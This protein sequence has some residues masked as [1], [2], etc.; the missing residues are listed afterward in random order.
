MIEG[1]VMILHHVF[2]TF[3]RP[4]GEEHTLGEY[5]ILSEQEI[6]DRVIAPLDEQ[7][8]ITLKE[9]IVHPVN[10]LQ[11]RIYRSEKRIEV[12]LLPDG[13][14]PVETEPE[15]VLYYFDQEVVAGVEECT[16]HFLPSQYMLEDTIRNRVEIETGSEDTTVQTSALVLKPEREQEIHIR[17]FSRR[18][19]VIF[20]CL[21]TF[22]YLGNFLLTSM[23]R[24]ADFPYPG[25]TSIFQ[26][27]SIITSWSI[28]SSIL[29]FLFLY[30]SRYLLIKRGYNNR[31]IA[32]TS[33]CGLCILLLVNIGMN[34]Q[35]LY[36]V[37][38]VQLKVMAYTSPYLIMIGVIV[39]SNYILFHRFDQLLLKEKELLYDEITRVLGPLLISLSITL[40]SGIFVTHL[41]LSTQ[42]RI[43]YPVWLGYLC[44]G[45][46]LCMLSIYLQVREL[47]W[48]CSTE[49]MI[50][51]VQD[52]PPLDSGFGD[53]VENSYSFS[54]SMPLSMD[55][56]SPV[57]EAIPEQGAHATM[58]PSS[59]QAPSTRSLRANRNKNQ[60][61]LFFMVSSLACLGNLLFT[62]SLRWVD[63]RDQNYFSLV[64]REQSI[65]T[66]WSVLSSILVFLLVSGI[67]FMSVKKKLKSMYVA[68]VTSCA[69]VLML[70]INVLLT[71]S[72]RYSAA[73]TVLVYLSPYLLM[74]GE[75]ALILYTWYY[76]FDHLLRREKALLYHLMMKLWSSILVTPFWFVISGVL[77]TFGSQPLHQEWRM[78][79]PLWFGYLLL[80]M[81][82]WIFSVRRNIR[83]LQFDLATDL[84]ERNRLPHLPS[85]IP[86]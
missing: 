8:F 40:L 12:L 33:A 46:I 30:G 21:C 29:I 14:T 68:A 81:I 27:P 45:V 55:L 43:V 6:I 10:I 71:F 2:L 50:S 41:T 54:D 15:H 57:T 80:G 86:Y 34:F 52:L 16:S 37:R 48:Q 20:F 65:V 19:N 70:L 11:L 74:I 82:F 13:A 73:S 38:G 56:Q 47:L 7:R 85:L 44:I 17:E 58:H 39:V 61:L 25:F 84:S 31:I 76:Q 9:Y 1:V 62:L 22:A 3:R 83:D 60:Y 42:Y 23:V 77:L 75:I 18:Q 5:N 67:T 36:Y 4:S 63:F 64:Y 28:T 26:D 79:T 78:I 66:L 51:L 72:L 59:S 53:G 24:W 49:Y 69:L 35:P 32:L